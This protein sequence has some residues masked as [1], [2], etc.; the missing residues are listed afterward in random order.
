ME[1]IYEDSKAQP[2]EA[3]NILNKFLI[4]DQVKIIIT[5]LSSVTNAVMPI[6]TRTHRPILLLA[7]ITS[8]SDITTYSSNFFRYFL[9]SADEVNA[10]VDYFKKNDIDNIGVLHLNDD[11]GEDAVNVLKKLFD[12]KIVYEDT[13]TASQKDFKNITAKIRTLKD[14]YIIGYGPTYGL[15]TKQIRESGYKGRIYAF[16]S[17]NSPI[18][19]DTAGEAAKG[20]IFSGTTFN[21]E[22]PSND[23]AKAFVR[24]YKNKYNGLPDHYAAYGYDIGTILAMLPETYSQRSEHL[25]TALLSMKHFNGVFGKTTID[26]SGDF[27][28]KVKLYKVS[29]DGKIEECIF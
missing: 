13:F 9:S 12:G 16:S 15:L 8:K 21:P 2:K 1:V 27:H 28:F 18:V 24:S 4:N 22:T 14:L 19:L 11:F 23:L 29:Y 20:V 25:K 10:M 7:S 17:F 3:I 6:L 26:S 5:T